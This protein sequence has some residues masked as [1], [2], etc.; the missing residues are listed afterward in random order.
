MNPFASIARIA[1]NPLF[2]KAAPL[3]GAAAIGGVGDEALEGVIEGHDNRVRDEAARELMGVMMD[4]QSQQDAMQQQA[5]QAYMQGADAAAAAMAQGMGGYEDYGS[6][7]GSSDGMY[8]LAMAALPKEALAMPKP[9]AVKAGQTSPGPNSM[10]GTAPKPAGP[11]IH[12]AKSSSVLAQV[13]L[14]M[15]EAL[16]MDKEALSPAVIGAAFGGGV[17]ASQGDGSER[18]RNALMGAVL[19]GTGGKVISHPATLGRLKG[20]VPGGK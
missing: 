9:T 8:S 5:A 16:G 18:I 19:G 4:A 20:M 2:R 3:A 7:L 11:G 14:V 17:G 1:R 15:A 12:M 10:A 6:Q 13:P